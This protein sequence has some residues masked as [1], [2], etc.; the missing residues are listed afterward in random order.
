[1]ISRTHQNLSLAGNATPHDPALSAVIKGRAYLRSRAAPWATTQADI[2]DER[3][4]EHRPHGV[5]GTPPH[6]PG[7]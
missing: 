5:V 3:V 6:N 4:N 7:G 2:I 1:M